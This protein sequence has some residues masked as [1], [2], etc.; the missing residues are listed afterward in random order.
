M[1]DAE[2]KKFDIKKI[3]PNQVS[4]AFLKAMNKAMKVHS[5]KEALALFNSSQRIF[6]DL[7]KNLRFGKKAYK[8]KLIIREWIDEVVEY[9]QGEYRC[10][11]HKKS[12]NA[13]TQYFSD[14]VFDELL[15]KETQEVRFTTKKLTFEGDKEQNYKVLQ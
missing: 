13:V 7:G 3:T 5:G 6:D 10:F 9:P 11:V 4:I 2:I 1:V 14:T 15:K 12:L 8:S